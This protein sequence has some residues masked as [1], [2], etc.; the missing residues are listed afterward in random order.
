MT[1]VKIHWTP[2]ERFEAAVRIFHQAARPQAVDFSGLLLWVCLQLKTT[3]ESKKTTLY[4][5]V[6]FLKWSTPQSYLSRLSQVNEEGKS[7]AWLAERLLI[8]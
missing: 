3:F 2:I 8:M 4:C 7:C 5:A 1:M 6:L